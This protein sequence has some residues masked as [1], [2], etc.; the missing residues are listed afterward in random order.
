MVVPA[1][2]GHDAA[3]L[4]RE[5]VRV[6]GRVC[7]A[8][9]AAD[10]DDLVQAALI[11]VMKRVE[12]PPFS[13][14]N[15][16]LAASYLYKVAH[17]VLID[18]IRKVRRRRETDLDESATDAPVD[19]ADPERAAASAQI[20]QG[21]QACLTTMLDDRRL[22]VTLHLQGHTVTEAAR[23]LDWPAKRTE[24]LVYRGLADLRACLTAKG[25]RP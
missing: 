24:N 7:P 1:P 4:R 5:L 18:E 9:L 19:A 23:L 25:L 22:A 20:G 8:W 16:P 13:E 10:R 2:P 14:G 6:V 15:A 11:R 12:S 3:A 17:S 21:I